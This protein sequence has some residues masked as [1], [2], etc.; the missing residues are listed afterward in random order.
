MIIPKRDR[1][2]SEVRYSAAA[3]RT[4]ELKC[5][6]ATSRMHKSNSCQG[7]K[8]WTNR[9]Q[10]RMILLPMVSYVYTPNWLLL[11]TVPRLL[12]PT[13]SDNLQCAKMKGKACSVCEDII[14]CLVRK[15]GAWPEQ[16]LCVG[17]QLHKCSGLQT[18]DS[19]KTLRIPFSPLSTYIGRH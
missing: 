10:T 13:C 7:E 9:L 16:A 6:L 3:A 19:L 11:E 5:L 8:S 14:V 2:L 4:L 1:L 15:K 17:L 18:L 12:P